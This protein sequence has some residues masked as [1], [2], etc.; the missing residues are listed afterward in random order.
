MDE[1]PIKP[2]SFSRGRKWA[3]AFNVVVSSLALLAILVMGNYL[4]SRHYWRLQVDSAKVT[5]SPLTKRILNSLTNHVKI[6]IYFDP[7]GDHE[8]FSAVKSLLKEYELNCPKIDLEYIDFTKPGRA[9]LV[10]EK[11]KF[12]VSAKGSRV[13]FDYKDRTRTVMSSELSEFQWNGKEFR[14][15]AFKGEQLFTSAIA[16]VVEPRRAKIYFLTGH[17][18]HDIQSDEDSAGYSKFAK[19]LTENDIECAVLDNLATRDIP[20]D[21][22]VLLVAG[23]TQVFLPQEVARIEQYLSRGGR[24]FMLLNYASVQTRGRLGFDS[25]FAAWNLDVGLNYVRDSDEAKA[26]Q[27]ELVVAS[28]FGAHPIVKPLLN[29]SLELV[30]PRSVGQRSALAGADSPKV[31]ELV[32]TSKAGSIYS[33]SKSLAGSEKHGSIPL[34]AAVEKGSIQG[35]SADRGVGRMVVVGDSYFLANKLLDYLSNYDFGL[36][37]VDWLLNR[38]V[39]LSEIPPHAV[40]DYKFNVTEH[41]MQTFRWI[42]L[43]VVPGLVLITGLGVWARRRY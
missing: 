23:P 36:L 37:A 33:S 42:F 11:Y 25:L 26:Q 19:V 31:S 4:A 35:V 8:M 2:P 21:C 41:Q 5:I 12:A 29:S 20:A 3:M 43:L 38:D 16:S 40:K 28:R 1:K 34:A 15:S 6:I 32:S 10:R 13:I 27:A 14:R 9:E 39:M 18:E 24:V 7:D 30:I 17:G 22:Q